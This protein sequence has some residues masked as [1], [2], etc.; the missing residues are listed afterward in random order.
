[1][2]NRGGRIKNEC[3]VKLGGIERNEDILK[4]MDNIVILGCG[5]SYHAGLYGCHYLKNLCNFNTVQ[6]FDDKEKKVKEEGGLWNRFFGQKS[7]NNKLIDFSTPKC[8]DELTVRPIT[9]FDYTNTPFLYDI[10]NYTDET[11]SG[12]TNVDLSTMVKKSSNNIITKNI[13]S[14][15]G[16]GSIPIPDIKLQT[17]A[18]LLASSTSGV[19]FIA[20][21]TGRL[22]RCVG[23]NAYLNQ[24]ENDEFNNLL[25][26][27][28]CWCMKII[29]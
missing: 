1:V 6:I 5:T 17:G 14:N 26:N 7:S 23:I 13:S 24:P 28:V 15:I 29:S 10:D 18:T 20:T 16:L 9:N 3:E 11:F 2:I 4:H 21:K 25:A 12:Y 8:L 27:C 19:A 22:T